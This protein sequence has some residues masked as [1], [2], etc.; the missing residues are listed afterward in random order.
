[1]QDQRNPISPEQI[2][3]AMDRARTLRSNAVRDIFSAFLSKSR[4]S[5]EAD[6][7]EAAAKA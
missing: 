5:A 6:A 1:M 4:A 7:P 3:A 2:E